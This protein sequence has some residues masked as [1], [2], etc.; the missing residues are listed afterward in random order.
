MPLEK[1]NKPGGNEIK[2]ITISFWHVIMMLIYWM[3][4][5]GYEG[6]AYWEL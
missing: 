4:E 1:S 2:W 5:L 3:K 6:K